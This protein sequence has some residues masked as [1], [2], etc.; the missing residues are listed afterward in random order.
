MHDAT[1]RT[2]VTLDPDTVEMVRKQVQRQRISFKKVL[3]NAIRMGLGSRSEQN[4]NSR[5]EVA[6]F[7]SDYLPGVDRVR[8]Q[9]LSD[10]METDEFLGKQ[11][12]RT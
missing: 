11:R 4:K 9:Q 6:T 12:S 5:V 2:T 8:L 7:R 3:N 1:M 10:E